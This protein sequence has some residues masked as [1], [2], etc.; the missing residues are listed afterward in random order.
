MSEKLCSFKFCIAAVLILKKALQMLSDSPLYYTDGS[1]DKVKAKVSVTVVMLTFCSAMRPT[2][3][4]TLGE[5]GMTRTSWFPCSPLS[6]SPPT[7]SSVPSTLIEEAGDDEE[8]ATRF[9]PT[10]NKRNTR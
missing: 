2:L 1:D 4:P 5:K 6:S 8:R 7:L 3:S 9:F 10:E